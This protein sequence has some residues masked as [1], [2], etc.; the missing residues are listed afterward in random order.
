MLALMK[1]EIGDCACSYC[2]RVPNE[3]REIEGLPALTVV[4]LVLGYMEMTVS[5]VLLVRG[6]RG[7]SGYA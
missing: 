2:S 3:Q 4:L 7:Y 1:R 5:A 6:E